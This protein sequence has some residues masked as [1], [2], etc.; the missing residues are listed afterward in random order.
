M[1][2]EASTSFAKVCIIR[3]ILFCTHFALA[4]CSVCSQQHY[5]NEGLDG[6]WTQKYNIL[7]LMKCPVFTMDLKALTSE[8]PPLKTM[9]MRCFYEG[10]FFK[11]EKE[12]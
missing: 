2:I 4:S 5:P 11:D 6:R 12:F 1:K 8:K 7:Q 9:S 10:I 3:I